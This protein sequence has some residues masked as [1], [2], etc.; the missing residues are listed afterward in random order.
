M[1]DNVIPI[2]RE[3]GGIEK[4]N[5][6]LRDALLHL[7]AHAGHVISNMGMLLEDDARL[8]TPEWRQKLG[9]YNRVWLHAQTVLCPG[10]LEGND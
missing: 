6:L 2:T 7:S 1:L 4:E 9:E 8:A 10:L 5:R 3:G